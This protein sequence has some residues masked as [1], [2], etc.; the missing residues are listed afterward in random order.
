MSV[1]TNLGELLLNATEA[2][3]KGVCV[4]TE[5]AAYTFE[6]VVFFVAAIRRALR[7]ALGSECSELLAVPPHLRG[8]ERLPDE[9]V[10]MI[11]LERGVESIAA[12][13]AVM[14]EGCAYN[15]F[16]V[17]EPVEKL[18]CWVEVARPAV[19]ISTP[20][21]LTRFSRFSLEAGPLGQFPRYILDVE[22]LLRRN[23]WKHESNELIAPRCDPKDLPGEPW[24]SGV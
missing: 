5:A 19:M 9:H 12:I 23:E 7:T 17:A 16:D 8:H 21:I 18:R 4:E 11:V 20:A 6:Q 22:K 3:P 10:V 15:A 2:R 1:E 13:H 14:L 24:K